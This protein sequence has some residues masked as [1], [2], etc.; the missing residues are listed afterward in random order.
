MTQ[1]ESHFIVRGIPRGHIFWGDYLIWKIPIQ[2]SLAHKRFML[3]LFLGLGGLVTAIIVVW[4]SGDRSTPTTFDWETDW[5]VERGFNIT[6]D[7]QGLQFPT[8][9]VFIPNPGDSP[10]DP[11][12]F[13]TELPGG[14]KVVTNDRTVFTFAEDFFIRHPQRVVPVLDEEVGMAGICLA[15]EH[16]QVFVT[17]SY[18][19]ADDIL[20]NNIVRFQSSPETFSLTPT[21]LVYFTEIFDS[22]P[23]LRSHQIGPCQVRGDLLYVSVADG[24][25]QDQSQV[26]DSV[27]GKVLRMD[28][29]GRPAPENPF[30][31]DANIEN[32]RN[33]VWASGLR[34]PF[35]LEIVG[36]GVFVADNGPDV[37]RFI[38]LEEGGNYLWDGTNAS[39]GTN[40]DAVFYPG[41]GVAHMEHY[42][43]V[44]NLF[45]DQ[46]RN[47]FFMTMTGNPLVRREGFP[48]IWAVPYDPTQGEL[49]AV[50]RPVLRFRG[51]Q[52][53]VLSALGFGP[54]GLY[55]APLLPNKAGFNG[56]YKITYEPETEYPFTL[57]EESNPVVLMNTLGCFACHSLSENR[58]GT[59]GPTLDQD[60]L[61]PRLESRLNSHEYAATLREVDE[62]ELEPFASFRD[63]RHAVDQAQGLDK[64]RTW[65]YY[66]I[67]EPRLIPS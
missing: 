14:I 16:G 63:A 50:P 32:S 51:G 62:L 5:A 39:I 35:G 23:S 41:R 65:L 22:Y 45:P 29:D 7:A 17:F 38:Q 1:S 20:R 9:I 42:P 12:Y 27:L 24:G 56:V 25:Q 8:A 53:Q 58:R 46:F 4:L 67:L 19:D 3:P 66:R 36:D 30:Y 52:V 34:N 28:L 44:S 18:H 26:L 43:P 11:L 47:N 6:V 15:P 48:A 61:V 49:S 59:I 54:D 57:K 31:E 33:Y 55:F 13:V 10:K 37:D 60:V 64:I 40:A 21:S 2:W